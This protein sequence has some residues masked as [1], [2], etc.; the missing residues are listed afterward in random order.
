MSYANHKYFATTRQLYQNGVTTDKNYQTWPVF[1]LVQDL[2]DLY[3][4]QCCHEDQ[5]KMN[6]LGWSQALV[7]WLPWQPNFVIISKNIP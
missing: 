2:S 6:A 7:T 4:I 1:E 5:A 3:N